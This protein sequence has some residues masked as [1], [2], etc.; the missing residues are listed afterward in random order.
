MANERVGCGGCCSGGGDS[1]GGQLVADR[2]VSGSGTKLAEIPDA[3]LHEGTL[4]WV[5]DETSVGDYFRLETGTTLTADNITVV[6]ALSGTK[7][8]VRVGAENPYWQEKQA[9]WS[10]DPVSGDDENAGW[11]SSTVQAD[12]RPLKTVRSRWSSAGSRTTDRVASTSR[13]SVASWR[14]LG[15]R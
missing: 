2:L 9:Y 12:S 5:R 7:Q 8:W 10:I 6:N 3:D 14:S 1:G 4:C 13:R 11:G 15:C